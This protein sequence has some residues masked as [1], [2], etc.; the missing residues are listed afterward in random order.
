MGNAKS[1][2]VILVKVE[3]AKASNLPTKEGTYLHV[4][5]LAL[6]NASKRQPDPKRMT[7][8]T[9]DEYQ[10]GFLRVTVVSSDTELT[11]LM[12]SSGGFFGPV[13][14]LDPNKNLPRLCVECDH[15]VV[16]SSYA[17]GLCTSPIAKRFRD[18]VT[19]EWPTCHFMREETK[20]DD[21]Y[22]RCGPEAYHWSPKTV[23]QEPVTGEWP[24]GQ[25]SI[26]DFEEE[27]KLRKKIPRKK[28][29][30]TR[31]SS[32]EDDDI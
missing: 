6:S 17:G 3:T 16:S 23:V 25:A 24:T 9:V 29:T 22:D 27:E 12:K 7:L 31:S 11:T 10:E 26:D 2:P 13:V 8:V 20:E 5:S 21:S 30:P 18:V 28:A 32:A 14:I 1:K 19:G 4:T 15:R